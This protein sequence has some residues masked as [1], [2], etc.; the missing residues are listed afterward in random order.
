VNDSPDAISFSWEVSTT[1]V[2]VEGFSPTATLE[3]DSTKTPKDKLDKLI[4]ILY[5][6]NAGEGTEATEPRL[7]LPNEVAS[8][9]GTV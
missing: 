3:I 1:P 8:I 4:N 6:T 7:P 2:E 9:V 5:G